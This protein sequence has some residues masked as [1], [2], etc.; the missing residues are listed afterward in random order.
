MVGQRKKKHHDDGTQMFTRVNPYIPPDYGLDLYCPLNPD[1]PEHH[2]VAGMGFKPCKKR[3]IPTH[4]AVNAH[5]MKSHRRGYTALERDREERRREEDRELQF[6]TI[7]SNQELIRA[8]LGQAETKSVASVLD[9]DPPTET[10]TVGSPEA[11]LY[12]SD[13]PSKPRRNPRK[14]QK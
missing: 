10:I 9:G 14:S 13:K 5:V 6:A 7:K 3:H 8:V 2:R 4:D 11:P 1:S 12:V